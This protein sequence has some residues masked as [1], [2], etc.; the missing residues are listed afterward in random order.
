MLITLPQ[1]TPYC[2]WHSIII[3]AYSEKSLRD[4]SSH[5]IRCRPIRRQNRFI[6]FWMRWSRKSYLRKFQIMQFYKGWRERAKEY[7]I[8]LKQN[9]NVYGKINIVFGSSILKIFSSSSATNRPTTSC[10]TFGDESAA[11][12][13]LLRKKFMRYVTYMFVSVSAVII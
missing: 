13:V 6:G 8:F 12:I 10:P 9:G 3:I 1:I 2:H 11:G 7:P 5:P 4:N